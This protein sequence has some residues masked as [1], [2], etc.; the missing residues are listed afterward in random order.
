M[1]E[2]AFA[3]DLSTEPANA[4]WPEEFVSRVRAAAAGLPL[5][6]EVLDEAA[7]RR[8][9]MGAILAVGQG[10]ARPPRLLVVRYQGGGE[11]EAPLAFVGKGI[12]FD[13]GGIRPLPRATWQMK[14]DMTGAATVVS[15]VI[16]SWPRRR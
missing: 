11:G 7:M 6:I 9:G 2:L 1:A 16:A 3:R 10:S 14:G 12:T 8:L 13:S 5:R 4:L 15:T